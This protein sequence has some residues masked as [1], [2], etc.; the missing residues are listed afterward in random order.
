MAEESSRLRVA[1]ISDCYLPRTGGIETQVAALVQQ[2]VTAGFEVRVITATA[3]A[4]S[5]PRPVVPREGVPRDGVPKL[6]LLTSDRPN[7]DV[8]RVVARMPWQLPIHPRARHH[9]QELLRQFPVDVVHVHLGAV[10]PF[11]WGGIRAAHKLKLPIVV[12]VHSMWG[13]LARAGYRMTEPLLH[14]TRP[15]VRLAAVSAVAAAAVAQALPRA[16]PVLVLPN[17]IDPA[18]WGPP[19]QPAA[20]DGRDSELRLVSVL[21]LAPRKRVLPLL[22]IAERAAQLSGHRMHLTVIGDGP[23]RHRAERQASR[24]QSCQVRFTGRL[25]RLGIQE[26]FVKADLFV[27]PSVRESFGLAALEARTWGLPVIARSQSGSGTFI[28]EGVTGCLVASDEAMAT[29]LADLAV[30]EPALRA[31]Q[32]STRQTPVDQTWPQL[33]QATERAYQAVLDRGR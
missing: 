11:A 1:H 20:Q 28:T 22:R 2:Q 21:R 5:A 30:D 27:Q 31:L 8:H 33:L 13:P 3:D 24:L 10:S 16:A 32:A 12:T 14:W 29:V 26:E 9:I 17:A 19:E 6:G 15:P 25:D 18:L 23:D 7:P 4:G